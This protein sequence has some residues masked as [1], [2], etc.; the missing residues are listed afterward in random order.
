[1]TAFT[2]FLIPVGLFATLLFLCFGLYALA[3]GGRFSKQNANKLM[4]MR[5]AAQAVTIGILMVFSWLI[6]QGN[7]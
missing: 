1:M 4:R 5:V 7:A 3:K 2:F 6:T